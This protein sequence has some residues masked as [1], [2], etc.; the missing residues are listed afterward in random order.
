MIVD[1]LTEYA[2]NAN[3]PEIRCI[4]KRLYCDFIVIEIPEEAVKKSTTTLP[5][6]VLSSSTVASAPVIEDGSKDKEETVKYDDPS[7]L[8]EVARQQNRQLLDNKVAANVHKIPIE[9]ENKLEIHK[10]REVAEGVCA[11]CNID[12]NVF[13]IDFSRKFIIEVFR[14]TLKMFGRSFTNLFPILTGTHFL[15]TV[16]MDFLK[17]QNRMGCLLAPFLNHEFLNLKMNL[18]KHKMIGTIENGAVGLP[19]APVIICISL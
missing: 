16:K 17:S 2:C 12:L 6:A 8:E 3:W 10:F 15:P 18:E 11:E 13:F 5:C 1:D 4:M 7:S 14:N 19:N 9:F